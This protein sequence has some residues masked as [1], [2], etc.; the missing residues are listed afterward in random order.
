MRQLVLR[1][2]MRGF[3]AHLSS[4]FPPSGQPHLHLLE[5]RFTVLLDALPDGDGPNL[6]DPQQLSLEATTAALEWL[7]KTLADAFVNDSWATLSA[8]LLRLEAIAGA[9]AVHAALM[10]PTRSLDSRGPLTPGPI[11]QSKKD[12]VQ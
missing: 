1:L 2:V 5:A 7:V 12:E 11:T 9:A 3:V 6:G 4:R 8:H 10:D